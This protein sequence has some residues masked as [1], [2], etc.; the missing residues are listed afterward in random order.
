MEVPYNPGH[1]RLPSPTRYPAGRTRHRIVGFRKEMVKLKG[2]ELFT[3]YEDV[4]NILFVSSNKE[5][6]LE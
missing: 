4:G 3:G 5:K 2:I 6:D 1:A